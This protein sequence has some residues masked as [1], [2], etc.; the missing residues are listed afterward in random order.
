MKGRNYGLRPVPSASS[1]RYAKRTMNWL[2]IGLLAALG[3][4]AVRGFFRGFIVE[5][6]ALLGIVVG[7]W[8]ATRFSANVADWIGLD[9]SKEVLAFIITFIGVLVLVYLLARALTALIDLAQLGLP[10][11]VAGV[12]FG[13]LRGAFVL[14]VLLNVLMARAELAHA[15]PKKLLEGSVMYAPLRSFAPFFIPALKESKWVKRALEELQ[16][17]V[18]PQEAGTEK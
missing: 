12:V 17:E 3:F 5:V 14:S 6:C 2:D 7:I 10:N 18:P 9:A 8:V 11:K 15:A 4:A 16:Q 13:T 1:K